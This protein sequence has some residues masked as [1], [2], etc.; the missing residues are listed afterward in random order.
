MTDQ[1]TTQANLTGGI[2]PADTEFAAELF[3]LWLH[4][5]QINSATIQMEGDLRQRASLIEWIASIDAR[6]T[7]CQATIAEHTTIIQEGRYTK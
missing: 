7:A 4:T 1:P 6:V 2:D 5:H 3:P